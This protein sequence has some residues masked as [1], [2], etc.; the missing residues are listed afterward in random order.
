VACFEELVDFS[1][2]A[3]LDR[4]KPVTRR[5]VGMRGLKSTSVADGNYLVDGGAER[6]ILEWKNSMD[7]LIKRRDGIT[8][9][10]LEPDFDDL[11]YKSGSA[12]YTPKRIE[13]MASYDFM[14]LSKDLA[15]IESDGVDDK[16]EWNLF[17]RY[18]THTFDDL[19]DLN[20]PHSLSR[21]LSHWKVD[22]VSSESFHMQHLSGKSTDDYLPDS[23]LYR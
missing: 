4:I 17:E 3:Y 2:V 12:S 22:Q 6:L 18:L 10:P 8:H 7:M 9:E 23:C 5:T 13:K 1:Q 20:E 14:L 16:E 15:P 19:E 11:L 21:M